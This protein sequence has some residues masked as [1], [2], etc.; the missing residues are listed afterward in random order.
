M[1]EHPYTLDIHIS[2]NKVYVTVKYISNIEV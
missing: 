2:L 1:F